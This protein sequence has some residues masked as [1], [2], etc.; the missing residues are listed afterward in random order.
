MNGLE[1]YRLVIHAKICM[2]PGVISTTV[3]LIGGSQ[4]GMQKKM[5]MMYL[6]SFRTIMHGVM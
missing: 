6:G 3:H 2:K 5:T 1:C 4:H